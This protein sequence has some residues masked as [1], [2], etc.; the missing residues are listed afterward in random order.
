MEAQPG[1]PPGRADVIARRSPR[2]RE[3][4]PGESGA[5]RMQMTQ[6]QIESVARGLAA[7]WGSEDAYVI[8]LLLAFGLGAL[9]ASLWLLG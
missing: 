7:R 9:A 1:A 5:G 8:A 3:D 6:R 2:R 4:Q